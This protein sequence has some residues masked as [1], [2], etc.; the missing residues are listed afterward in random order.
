MC[1][2]FFFFSFSSTHNPVKSYQT[3]VTNPI[4]HNYFLSVQTL[5]S[6]FSIPGDALCN[7]FIITNIARFLSVDDYIVVLFRNGCPASCPPR[8]RWTL[9]FKSGAPH[10]Q[11]AYTFPINGYSEAKLNR[12]FKK[13]AS[14]A[15]MLRIHTSPRILTCG[16]DVTIGYLW[17]IN[18]TTSARPMCHCERIKKTLQPRNRYISFRIV[19]LL[20]CD[21][22]CFFFFF[23][24]TD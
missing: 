5:R 10:R 3:D 9:N 24:S 7:Y 12:Q 8:W 16:S 20:E 15:Q 11:R 2:C 21:Y 6:A 18:N 1:R 22:R 4:R 23:L 14:D 19:I 13:P 17:K